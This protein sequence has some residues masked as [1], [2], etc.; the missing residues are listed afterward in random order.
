MLA[1]TISRQAF[2]ASAASAADTELN[3]ISTG[4]PWNQASA[5]GGPAPSG[6]S[7]PTLAQQAASDPINSAPSNSQGNTGIGFTDP[8]TSFTDDSSSASFPWSALINGTVSV[9]D[10][11]IAAASSHTPPPVVLPP[12][13]PPALFFGVPLHVLLLGAGA[14]FLLRNK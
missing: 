2:G 8:S 11:A 14:Y 7:T 5:A 3:S 4:M 10:A 6:T 9:A 1:S 13:A 12:P